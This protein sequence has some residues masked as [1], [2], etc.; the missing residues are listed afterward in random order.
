[1][2]TLSAIVYLIGCI[3][4]AATVGTVTLEALR[5]SR[6]GDGCFTL[7]TRDLEHSDLHPECW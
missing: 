4:Q 3:F 2:F 1:M 6:D 7:S 5:V